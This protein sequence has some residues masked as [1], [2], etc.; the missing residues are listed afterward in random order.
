MA[1]REKFPY[2]T[3]IEIVNEQCKV[4]KLFKDL[5]VHQFRV[6]DIRRL[7]HGVTRHLVRIPV[8][9]SVNILKRS[10]VRMRS[11]IKLG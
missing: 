9:Q 10:N 8:K 5:G 1:Y 7:P 4:L 2:R 6:V 11:S 3:S